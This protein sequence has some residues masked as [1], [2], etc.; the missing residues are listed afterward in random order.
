M[1]ERPEILLTSNQTKALEKKFQAIPYLELTE[2][3]KLAKSINISE[4]R[5]QVSFGN[6][7]IKSKKYGWVYEVRDS[8]VTY[9]YSIILIS[10]TTC[11]LQAR[12]SVCL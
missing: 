10:L 7:R 9:K 5:L 12:L 1:L 11:I 2:K 6:R 3:L 8:L 4:K